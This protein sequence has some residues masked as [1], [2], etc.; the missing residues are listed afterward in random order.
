MTKPEYILLQT[1]LQRM[2]TA[3]VVEPT[4]L[5]EL[6]AVEG[7]FRGIFAVL[8]FATL[9]I[10]L[11][12]AAIMAGGAWGAIN[13]PEQISNLKKLKEGLQPVTFTPQAGRNAGHNMSFNVVALR[14]DDNTVDITVKAH[15][16]YITSYKEAEDDP[17]HK[18]SMFRDSA[19]FSLG[20]PT[21]SGEPGPH[22][23]ITMDPASLVPATAVKSV[24]YS[25]TN[26]WSINGG[27]KGGVS[28]QG[29]AADASISGGYSFSV[30]AS[31]TREDFDM[32]RTTTQPLATGWM[33]NLQTMYNYSQPEP[34]RVDNLNSII[35]HTI[36]VNWVN[37][38]P[39]A[40]RSDL[41]LEYMAAYSVRGRLPNEIRIP[42]QLAQRL[43][44]A[45]VNGRWG[46]DG[47][48]VG[49]LPSVLPN[50]VITKGTIVVDTRTWTAS[51]ADVQT[52]FQNSRELVDTLLK[53]AGA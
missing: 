48:K 2:S 27:F 53:A 47:A 20:A 14:R 36:F 45:E 39:Q 50:M 32:A 34:Y 49:G 6:H 35:G 25:Y 30:T 3:P 41:D 23:E 29:G 51:L 42:V 31:T 18:R 28:S 12:P 24:S 10:G 22:P 26:S 33:S 37:E 46:A 7:V 19:A 11:L 21:I 52:E 43:L 38:V 16:S 15:A 4:N 44:H 40:A 1:S 13:N 17:A 8:P 9:G 5:D